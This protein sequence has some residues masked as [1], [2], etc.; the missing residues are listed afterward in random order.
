MTRPTAL[1]SLRPMTDTQAVAC[2]KLILEARKKKRWSQTKLAKEISVLEKKDPPLT[3]Q[4]IQS[5]EKGRTMP[6]RKRAAFVAKVLGEPKIAGITG[7]RPAPLDEK[8]ANL[9]KYWPW[10]SDGEKDKIVEL[11]KGLIVEKKKRV[12]QEHR[13]LSD[14]T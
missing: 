7:S 14:I 12:A 6:S 4:T 13:E 10:L 3:Y 2:G 8:T 9:M 1:G 11:A 5:W